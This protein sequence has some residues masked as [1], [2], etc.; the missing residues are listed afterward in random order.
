MKSHSTILVN[1][2]LVCVFGFCVSSCYDDP[3][4]RDI[5]LGLN[6]ETPNHFYEGT[7]DMIEVRVYCSTPDI[8]HLKADRQGKC[9]RDY[10]HTGSVLE[11]KQFD[12]PGTFDYSINPPAPLISYGGMEYFENYDEF[13]SEWGFSNGN[14]ATFQPI[15]NEIGTSCWLIME[16]EKQ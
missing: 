14:L 1:L 9:V 10:C 15:G 12:I 16:W 5:N 11:I 7:W 2:F 8:V 4:V 6:N 3:P 13:Y